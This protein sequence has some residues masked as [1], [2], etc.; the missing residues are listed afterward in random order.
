MTLHEREG[1]I[2]RIRQIRRL[3]APSTRVA[4]PGSGTAGHDT[5]QLEAR[6]AHLEEL[7]QGLQDSVHRES[8]RQ[9][10]RIAELEAQIQPAVLGKALSDHA[11]HH[12]L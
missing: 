3:A 10:K 7:L 5:A 6:I 8:V 2:S 11:R 9:R 4:A 12:G 1:L